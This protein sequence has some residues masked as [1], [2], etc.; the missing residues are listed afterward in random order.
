MLATTLLLAASCSTTSTRET[1]ALALDNILAASHRSAENSARDLYRHPKETLLFF[2]IRPE[3]RV[4]EIWPEPGW[5]TEIIAPL[6]RE[7]GKY[8]AAVIAPDSQSKY[9]T[10]RLATYQ[11]KLASR[12]DLYSAVQI[13]TFPKDGGEVVPPASLDMVVTFRNIHHWMADGFAEQAFAT[14]YKALKPGGVFGVVEH[15]GNPGV[16]QDPMA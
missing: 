6:V 9:V 1:T 3:M 11:Q 8:Y 15:R 14:A 12:P 13:V 7:H 2:G 5:Y 10:E 16:A 4:L